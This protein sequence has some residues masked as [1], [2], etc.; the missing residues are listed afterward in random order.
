[1]RG[2]ERDARLIREA[3]C[4]AAVGRLMLGRFNSWN[5]YKLVGDQ[6]LESLPRRQLK[7]GAVDVRSRMRSEIDG[8]CRGN[9]KAMTAKKLAALY[10]EVQPPYGLRLSLSEF[11]RRFGS[12]TE[13]ARKGCP[14]HATV[15]ITL[16]GLQ[17]EF[18]ED[19]LSKDLRQHV[20]WA[21]QAN[22][23]LSA[24]VDKPQT[25][26]RREQAN[27]ADMRRRLL[28]SVRASLF[29][30]YALLEAYFNG[31]GWEFLQAHGQDCTLSDKQRRFLAGEEGSLRKKVTEFP[32]LIGEKS[33]D[34]KYKETVDV[35]FDVLKPFRDSVA[36]PSPFSAP[37]KFGGYDKLAKL[38][39]ADY[40]LAEH[41]L[42]L[43]CDILTK[44]HECVYGS[45]AHM[46]SWLS[47]LLYERQTIIERNVEYRIGNH[48]AK[49]Q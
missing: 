49:I 1:M 6:T 3:N 5:E 40:P 13:T 20:L 25:I 47:D 22:V 4:A 38:F 48:T 15:S 46:P 9:F 26:L 8:F 16:W 23:E 30:S 18:A 14:K 33:C 36:H 24:M 37:E 39:A 32:T 17:F 19:H 42:T 43:T 2:R 7:T 29:S 31:L 41:A 28:A 34:D 44:S 27:I 11:E 12:I 35:L 45:N 21:R 10:E